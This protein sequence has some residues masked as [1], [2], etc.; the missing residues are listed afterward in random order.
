[1]IV[2][3]KKEDIVS[4][5]VFKSGLPFG[6]EWVSLLQLEKGNS[7]HFERFE[8]DSYEEAESLMKQYISEKLT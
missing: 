1:M 3:F 5:S 7:K 8:A 2:E 6:K 4:T